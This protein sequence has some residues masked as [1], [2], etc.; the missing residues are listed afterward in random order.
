MNFDI[1]CECG[2]SHRV[3]I[4]LAGTESAC[5]CG[6]HVKIPSSPRLRELAGLPAYVPD[7]EFVIR[8][9]HPPG[10]PAVRNCLWCG[11]EADINWEMQIVC[12]SA[13]ERSRG[14]SGSLIGYVLG[15][16]GGLFANLLLEAERSMSRGSGVDSH[17]RDVM[18]PASISACR[19]CARQ[20]LPQQV[21][22][23]IRI[24]SWPLWIAAI[25]LLICDQ[26]GIA[27]L[28]LFLGGV[29]SLLAGLW[30]HAVQARLRKLICT[31]PEYVALFRKYPHAAIHVTASRTWR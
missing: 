22:R 4:G 12:E 17:G 8:D 18:V 6:R 13:W 7:P 21:P 1:P 11:H 27:L 2:R 28:L 24:L 19:F 9:L 23:L 26:P 10:E 3:S 30:H 15:E 29:L 31:T 5:P 25:G 20:F 16:I 14:R